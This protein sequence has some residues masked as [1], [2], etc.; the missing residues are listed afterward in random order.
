MVFELDIGTDEGGSKLSLKF[1]L[2]NFYPQ[3]SFKPVSPKTYEK[4]EIN[5]TTLNVIILSTL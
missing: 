3:Q 2:K 5:F 1:F 4:I